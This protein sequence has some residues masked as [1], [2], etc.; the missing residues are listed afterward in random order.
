MKEGKRFLVSYF[1]WVNHKT[2]TRAASTKFWRVLFCLKGGKLHL[3]TDETAL[4]QCD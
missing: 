4:V 1:C 2:Q 3:K